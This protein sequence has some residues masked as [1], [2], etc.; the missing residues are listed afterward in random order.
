MADSGDPGVL[1]SGTLAKFKKLGGRTAIACVSDG[2][3]GNR[4]APTPMEKLAAQ[5]LGHETATAKILGAKLHWLGLQDGMLFRTDD[6]VL[7]LVDLIRQVQPTI[8]ITHNPDDYHADNRSV[9]QA[10]FIAAGIAPTFN[11]K[12]AHAANA[13]RPALFYTESWISRAFV[14]TEY[15]DITG[16]WPLKR[17]AVA[18]NK[19]GVRWLRDFDKMSIFDLVESTARSR[20][21]QYGCTFAEAFRTDSNWPQASTRRLLP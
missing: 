12:T 5:R 1:C 6:Y 10:T 2:A 9:A 11:I 4:L 13:I 20:G 17:K 7:K 3:G 8:V 15:V 21:L 16:T 19:I 14:P 18:A